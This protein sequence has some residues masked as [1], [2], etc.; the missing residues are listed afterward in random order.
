V[1]KLEDKAPASMDRF[2]EAHF[3]LHAMER[4]YH[5][6]DE[7]RWSLGGFLRSLKEVP[8][9]IGMEL[10]KEVGFSAWYKPERQVLSDDPLLRFLAEH[11]DFIVHRGMLLPKSSGVIGITK[12]RGIKFGLVFPIDPRQSSDTAMRSYLWAIKHVADDILGVLP[13]DDGFEDES[14]LPCVKRVWRLEP[15]EEDVLD[16]C[17]R[18]W[19]RLGEAIRTVALRIGCEVPHLSL[20]CLHPSENAQLKLYSRQTLKDWYDQLPDATGDGKSSVIATQSGG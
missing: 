3:H 5:L 20:S 4:F 18:A 9:L 14:T 15:F 16:L 12:G 13:D 17:A 7:F 10:Q 19:L 1:P 2:E 6:A 11:R 8:Q